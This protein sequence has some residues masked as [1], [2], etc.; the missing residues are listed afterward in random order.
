MWGNLKK[1]T[2]ERMKVVFALLYMKDRMAEHWRNAHIQ[3]MMN[4][5]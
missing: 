4:N 5:K 2:E 1:F 3:E